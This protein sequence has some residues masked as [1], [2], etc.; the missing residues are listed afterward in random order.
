MRRNRPD[1]PIEGCSFT[2]HK[3]QS[4]DGRTDAAWVRSRDVLLR[5]H[6]L[7]GLIALLMSDIDIIARVPD[8]VSV[9]ATGC[10]DCSSRPRL[11]GCFKDVGRQKGHTD[12]SIFQTRQPAHNETERY[13]ETMKRPMTRIVVLSCTFYFCGRCVAKSAIA[14]LSVYFSECVL[15]SAIPHWS[16]VGAN[17]KCV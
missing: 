3:T 15:W 7:S 5:A 10:R 14:S 2:Q 17:G 6:K 12:R 4:R 8:S 16:T 9:S 1:H 11:S 13:G